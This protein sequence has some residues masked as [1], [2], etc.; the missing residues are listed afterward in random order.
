MTKRGWQD[1]ADVGRAIREARASSGCDIASPAKRVVETLAALA[2]GYGPL[3]TEYHRRIYNASPATL[4][5]VIRQA[6]DGAQTLLLVGHNPGLQLLLLNLTA[7]DDGVLRAQIAEL[8]PTATLAAIDLSSGEL[9][10]LI[11]R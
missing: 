1:A 9:V 7:G 2:D 5:E 4:L 11:I 8:F 10:D 6:N 3:E